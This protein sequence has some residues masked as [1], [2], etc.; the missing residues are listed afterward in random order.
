MTITIDIQHACDGPVPSDHELTHWASSALQA[1]QVEDAEMTIRM[2]S[3][4]ESQALNHTYRQKD[5]PT[6]VLSF[7]F[8][9]DIPLDLP[10]LGDLV[11]C[12]QVVEQEAD[13]QNKP[14]A[15]HWAHMVVHGTLHLLGYDHINDEEAAEMEQLETQIL[16]SFNMPDPYQPVNPPLSASEQ[17][18]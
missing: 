4:E 12:A 10:L 5:K 17:G 7:P 3:T 2:V 16:A 6:N 13:E 18:D 14:V 15:N 9:S 11:I 8:E 1:L